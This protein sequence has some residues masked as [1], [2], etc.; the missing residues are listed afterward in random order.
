MKISIIH[1][2]Y[3]RNIYIRE[4]VI[5]N[6]K[7]LK[8]SGIDYQY[9]IFNDKGDINIEEDVR[10]LINDKIEYHYSDYNFGQGVCTGGWVGALPLVKG[11]LI[12]NMGQ[13]DIF[14]SMFYKNSIKSLTHPDIYLSYS[15]GFVV[16]KDLMFSG[17]LMGP[18][19]NMDYSNPKEVFNSWFQ[20]KGNILTAANNNIPAPGV[21]YKKE[22]HD[23][24]GPPDLNE[25]KGSADF[26]YW[27]RVL[28]NGLGVIYNP[29][30]TWLYRMSEYSY[31]SKP[32]ARTDIW[33]K[34]I[35]NKYQ[36]CITR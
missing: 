21:I 4:S 24:I 12:H 5:L 20:R 22:L 17:Q 30:P 13:D 18:I 31:G 16:G 28:F 7:S 8:E 2:V 34:N 25:F 10:D 32:T 1:N 35:L 29:S 26:E 36:K 33:N 3:D 15:N 6:V 14:S 23:K 9:I 11:D 19:Q 27:A